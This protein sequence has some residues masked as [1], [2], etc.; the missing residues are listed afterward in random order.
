MQKTACY[1]TDVTKYDKLFNSEDWYMSLESVDYRIFECC[2]DDF[3]RKYPDKIRSA[4]RQVLDGLII[5]CERARKTVTAVPEFMLTIKSLHQGQDYQCF[6]SRFNR[7][8]SR[9]SWPLHS[10]TLDEAIEKCMQLTRINEDDVMMIILVGTS[11]CLGHNREI[12][13]KCAGCGQ[14][15]CQYCTNSKGRCG[16]C[17]PMLCWRTDV[18]ESICEICG[19]D[20]M[21]ECSTSQEYRRGICDHCLKEGQDPIAK[22]DLSEGPP[23]VQ[24]D[25]HWHS[26]GA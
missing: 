17:D 8:E 14:E 2:R 5:E 10:V 6:I 7:G 25:K 22:E 18:V 21:L 9:R 19:L 12:I 15:V 26:F 13:G 3:E 1:V 16:N 11:T 20:F 23:R 4:N 24:M